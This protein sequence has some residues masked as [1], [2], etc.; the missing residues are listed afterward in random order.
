MSRTDH[1]CTY[2][3]FSH[4]KE[5]QI[6]VYGTL[7]WRYTCVLDELASSTLKN[8]WFTFCDRN[9]A[10]LKKSWHRPTSPEN[11]AEKNIEIKFSMPRMLVSLCCQASLC[12]LCSNTLCNWLRSQRVH[13]WYCTRW[14]INSKASISK[15][16]HIHF[17]ILYPLSTE[18]PYNSPLQ[19]CILEA[20]CPEMT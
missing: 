3:T 10:L 16:L 6:L 4:T 18:S 12:T 15:L 9:N 5:E 7:V 20:H 2:K 1:T 13:L 8:P 14:L 11:S 19:C 17:Y